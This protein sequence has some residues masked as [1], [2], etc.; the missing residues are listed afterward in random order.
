MTTQEMTTEEETTTAATSVIQE[1]VTSTES[2][3]GDTSF[4]TDAT[5]T[6]VV[7][8][9]VACCCRCCYV[10]TEQER[11]NVCYNEILDLAA[12]CALN[13]SPVT[14][15]PFESTSRPPFQTTAVQREIS[16]TTPTLKKSAFPDRRA[17]TPKF[18]REEIFIEKTVG[19]REREETDL[20]YSLEDLILQCT[21]DSR[22]CNKR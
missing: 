12:N 18:V 8:E 22:I 3:S 21:Y 20:G 13:I 1:H 10:E 16:Y 11:C 7:R 4:A 5:T 2:P 19:I 6:T 9:S 15:S 14:K 17:L